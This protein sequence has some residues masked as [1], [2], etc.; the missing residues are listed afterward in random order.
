L[1]LRG[2]WERRVLSLVVFLVAVVPVATASAGP[3]FADA[4]GTV[5]VR[6][7]VERTGPDGHGW[8]F[9][10]EGNDVTGPAAELA[11]SVG[12]L[13]RP[14]NGGEQFSPE[15]TT[16]RN[17]PLMWQDGQCAHVRL[18]KGR[19]PTASREI[20]VTEATKFGLGKQVRLTGA[21][22]STPKGVRPAALRVVG[23]YR[24]INVS[25]PFWFGRNL[26]SQSAGFDD[27]NGDPM[28]TVPQTAEDTATPVGRR[29]TSTAVVS[30]DP[31][32]ITGV[33]I[34]ALGAVEARAEK[35]GAPKV[36]V[37]VYTQVPDLLADLRTQSGA[38]GV[39]ALLVIAQLVALGWLMLYL[40]VSDLVIARGPEIA[41]ARLRGKGRLRVWRFGLVEPL[42]LLAAALAAGLVIGNRIAQVMADSLLPTQ[43]MATVPGLAVLAAAAVPLGGVVAAAIAARNMAHRPITEEWRRTPRPRARGWV[44]D[45]AVLA[46]TALGLVELLGTGVIAET[47]GQQSGSLAVPGL[48]AVA[49]AL[50]AC[51]IVPFC[52]RRL[53]ALTRRVGGIG[54]FLALRQIARGPATTG[55]LIVLSTAFGMATFATAAWSVTAANFEQV[56]RTHNGADSVLTVRADDVAAFRRAVDRADP[57]G[58]YAAPV[59]SVPGPPPMIATDPERFAHVAAWDPDWSGTPLTDLVARLHVPTAPRV[60]L[61][62]DRF[63][64]HVEPVHTPKS[65]QL[66]LFAEFRVPGESSV[67]SIPLG[68]ADRPVLEWG[69]PSGC[70]VAVCELRGLRGDVSYTAEARIDQFSSLDIQVTGMETRTGGRWRAVD[71][72]LTDPNRWTGTGTAGEGGLTMHLEAFSTLRMTPTSFPERI[73]ALVNGPLTRDYSPGL[74]QGFTVRSTAVARTAA[75][76]GLAEIG[77]VVDLDLADRVAYSVDPD[78]EFQVWVAP[79]HLDAVRDRLAAQGYPVFPPRRVADLVARYTTEGPGLALILL[80]MAALAA[81]ALALGRSVLA[82]HTAARRRRYELTA[83]RATGAR[84]GALRASLLLEQLITLCAGTLAGLVAGLVA[85]RVSL[86]HIPEFTRL[87]ITPPLLYEPS[88]TLVSVIIG[89]ALLVALLAAALTGELLLRGIHTDQLRQAPA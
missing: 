32:K 17:Y 49:G 63:R 85:A 74:D 79:G 73:P 45:A 25:D 18:V 54:V 52:A 20:M 77:T 12:F 27:S 3:I 4:A 78:A 10:S 24:P 50:L 2:L 19:C 69:L 72:G 5:L 89:A 53:F 16:F 14:V 56:A 6:S 44:I 21:L 42:V 35:L 26:F 80:F 84:A 13:S 86:P 62:G 48:L 8:R 64:L 65:W 34:P 39:P 46:V 70:R 71:A 37:L 58:R 7:T 61:T 36:N 38:L 11:S 55:S 60:T 57:S 41:L 59:V 87:P 33:D 82:L 30:I 51:R 81:A 66:I 1:T 9:T 22:D 68:R 31:A 83:L 76:P 23:I 29:W 15:T 88:S 67:A 40:T 47:S 43:V 75:L 28:L